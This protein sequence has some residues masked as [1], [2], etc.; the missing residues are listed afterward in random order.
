MAKGSWSQ[1]RALEEARPPANAASTM[2][3]LIFMARSSV[4]GGD[5]VRSLRSLRPEDHMAVGSLQGAAGGDIV[6]VLLAQLHL[7][8]QEEIDVVAGYPLVQRARDLVAG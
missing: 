7:P 2:I 4:L 1:A 6:V 3:C 5:D 8:H